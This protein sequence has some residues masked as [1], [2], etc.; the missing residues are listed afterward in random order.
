MSACPRAIAACRG[1]SVETNY[2]SIRAT[3]L[4][5]IMRLGLIGCL[6]ILFVACGQKRTGEK[7]IVNDSSQA[8][9][10]DIPDTTSSDDA[11]DAGCIRGEPMPVTINSVFPNATFVLDSD[12]QTSTETVSLNNSDKLIIKN[13][14]CEYYVLTFR[15]ETKRFQAD[16]T[17]MKYWL[18]RAVVLMKEI[19]RG[20]DAPLDIDGG[21][22]AMDSVHRENLEYTLGKEI[23][24][25]NDDIRDFATLDRIQ[26]LGDRVFAVEVSYATGPL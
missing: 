22:A 5:R 15:F 11:Y 10:A 24:Y 1:C 23:V 2:P 26:K 3:I 20:L 13:W 25:D 7:I 17:D 12:K 8:A 18:G 14:G 16:T 6:V 9:A 19:Q 4:V 21:T